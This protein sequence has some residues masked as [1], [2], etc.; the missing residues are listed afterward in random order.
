MQTDK[1]A[2][3]DKK[4]ADLVTE[5]CGRKYYRHIYQMNANFMVEIMA[6]FL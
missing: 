4:F 5:N 6:Q 2:T 1:N 3:N